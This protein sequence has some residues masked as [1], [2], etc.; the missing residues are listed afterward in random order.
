MGTDIDAQILLLMDH[1]KSLARIPCHDLGKLLCKCPF[2]TI[3]VMAK[4]S[5]HPKFQQH[6]IFCPRKIDGIAAIPA[7]KATAC[8]ATR[9]TDC[10][11]DCA[12]QPKRDLV[13]LDAD[14]SDLELPDIQKEQA[15]IM[16]VHVQV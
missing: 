4:E 15:K 13:I 8:C 7:M 14:L 5:F 2:E 11:M 10:Q 9:R 16:S 3:P 1:S 12:F 6:G